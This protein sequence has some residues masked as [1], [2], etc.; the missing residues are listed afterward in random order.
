MFQANME[1]KIPL[2]EKRNYKKK[3]A[4]SCA[5]ALSCYAFGKRIVKKKF[6]FFCSFNIFALHS[7][8]NDIVWKFDILH[9]CRHFWYRK[10]CIVVKLE[11]IFNF[12]GYIR[13]RQR[14]FFL[15]TWLSFNSN[16]YR[17]L[18]DTYKIG[19]FHLALE[20]C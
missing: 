3:T 18:D 13:E 6:N 5:F 7:S 17:S 14:A 11:W 16:H 10:S 8:K 9:N 12:Y 4:S 19:Y 1:Q 2:R 20:R 15:S